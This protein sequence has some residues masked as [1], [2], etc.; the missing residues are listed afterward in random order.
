MSITKKNKCPSCAVKIGQNHNS[1]CVL[2]QCPYCGRRLHQCMTQPNGCSAKPVLWPPP[3]DDRI[4]WNG[5]GPGEEVAR[6]MGWAM[7]RVENRMVPCDIDHPDAVADLTRVA[8]LCQWDRSKKRL[9]FMRKTD[10]PP[11]EMAYNRRQDP[12]KKP[13]GNRGVAGIR[14]GRGGGEDASKQKSQFGRASSFA[15]HGAKEY[16][17]HTKTF[18]NRPRQ[19]GRDKGRKKAKWRRWQ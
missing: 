7:R 3:A 1:G 15:Q 17:G 9:V 6:Q 16:P 13:E 8:V 2:E 19:G 18:V 5:F 14:E 12:T 4:P 11:A 10:T